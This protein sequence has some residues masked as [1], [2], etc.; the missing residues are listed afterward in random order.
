MAPVR[1]F[2]ASEKQN[3]QNPGISFFESFLGEELGSRLNIGKII[4]KD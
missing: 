2:V 3:K 1:H 4:L